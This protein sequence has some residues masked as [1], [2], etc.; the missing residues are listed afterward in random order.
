MNKKFATIDRARRLAR[1]VEVE[2]LSGNDEGDDLRLE[3][4]IL[5]VANSY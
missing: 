2:Y 1:D 5:N 3:D 4:A